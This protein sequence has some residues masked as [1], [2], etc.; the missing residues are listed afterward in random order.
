MDGP[1]SRRANATLTPCPVKDHLY[2]FG[3]EYFD[4]STVEIYADLYRY[5]PD[6]N[7]WRRFTSPTSPGPRSA[8]QVWAPVLHKEVESRPLTLPLF[9]PYD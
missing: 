7:E 3:G 5:A 2:L 8:H 9:N 6:K 1:P 4:G